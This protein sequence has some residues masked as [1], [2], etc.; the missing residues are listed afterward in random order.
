M[1]QVLW[2]ETLL[3][4]GGGLL[5]VVSPAALIRLLGLPAYDGG[6]WPRMLGGVL[7]G[8]GVAT[9]IEGWLPGSNGLGIAGCIAVNLAGTAVLV[10]MLVLAPQRAAAR[11]RLILWGLVLALVVLSLIEI[12]HL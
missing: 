6:F 8:L 10:G 12:A 5:L 3:K 7:I 9:F 4:L 11:G 2:I 1:Q